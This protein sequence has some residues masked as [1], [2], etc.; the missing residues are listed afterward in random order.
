MTRRNC[1]ATAK[2]T[3]E[4]YLK[5]TWGKVTGAAGHEIYVRKCYGKSL[6]TKPAY[7]AKSSKTTSVTLK[8]LGGKK[9]STTA[10]Y[11][12]GVRAYKYVNGKKA[13]MGTSGMRTYYYFIICILYIFNYNFII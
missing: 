2:W 10:N 13:Y 3:K 1:D 8:K 5:L 4:N 9:F 12:Y 7:T 11:K 6:W